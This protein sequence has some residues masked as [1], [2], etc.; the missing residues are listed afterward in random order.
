MIIGEDTLEFKGK[1]YKISIADIGRISYGRQSLWI[2][3][4]VNKWVKIEYDGGKKALFA[5]GSAIGWGGMF[6]GTKIIYHAV[7]HLDKSSF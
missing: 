7:K 6:G 2:L 5:D 4:F 1:K 3:D